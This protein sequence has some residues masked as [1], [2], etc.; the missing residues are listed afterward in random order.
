MGLARFD[1]VELLRT[2]AQQAFGLGLEGV[3]DEVEMKAVLGG[4]RLR[5]LVE[6]NAR[7]AAVAGEQDPVLG[8]RVFRN[9][10][11][12]VLKQ[13][14]K[15]MP[16]GVKTLKAVKRVVVRQATATAIQSDG[17]WSNLVLENGAWKVAD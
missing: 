2:E 13:A 4:L 7:A 1:L 14:A 6:H 15:S 11:P 8:R 9:L 12:E 16:Q 17:G 10:P 5:H 3:A